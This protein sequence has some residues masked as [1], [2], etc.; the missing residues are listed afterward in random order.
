MDATVDFTGSTVPHSSLAIHDGGFEKH[1]ADSRICLCLYLHPPH[2]V[3]PYSSCVYLKTSESCELAEVMQ[4]QKFFER[5]DRDNDGEIE[6]E[7]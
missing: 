2:T 3:T 7:P 4:N 1:P 6:V 5:N